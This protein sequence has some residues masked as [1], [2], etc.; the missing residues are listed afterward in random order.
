MGIVT[1]GFAF[2]PL[3]PYPAY[4]LRDHPLRPHQSPTWQCPRELL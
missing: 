4:R 3:I 2:G 1:F